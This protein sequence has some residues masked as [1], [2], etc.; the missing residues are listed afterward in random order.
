MG[1]LGAALWCAGAGAGLLGPFV[2]P[3]PRGRVVSSGETGQSPLG[4]QGLRS[5]VAT[6]LSLPS[7]WHLPLGQERIIGHL[8]EP[9]NFPTQ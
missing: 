6:S 9:W 4:Q 5:R 3:A 2:C 8:C 1:G 7:P